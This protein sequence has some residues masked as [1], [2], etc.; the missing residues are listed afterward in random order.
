MSMSAPQP[1]LPPEQEQCLQRRLCEGDPLAPAELCLSYLE[2]LAS[3]LRDNHHTLDESLLLTAAHE[4]VLGLIKR[5]LSCDLSKLD[6]FAYLRMAAVGDLRNLLRQEGRHHRRREPWNVVENG[7][8]AGNCSGRED[9]PAVL[10]ERAELRQAAEDA[11]RSASA[12]WAEAERRVLELMLRGEKRTEKFAAVL[13]LEGLPFAEQQE[14]VKRVKE[15]ILKRL[16]RE[17]KRHE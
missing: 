16:K 14:E 17:G 7:E 11:L 4:A 5:P 2:P 3:W 1:L 13:G 15:R 10:L 6:L 12:N 9:D 8:E